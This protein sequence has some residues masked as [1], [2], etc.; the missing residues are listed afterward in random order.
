MGQRGTLSSLFR[1]DLHGLSQA[2]ATLALH[3]RLSQLATIYCVGANNL[4]KEIWKEEKADNGRIKSMAKKH[5]LVIIVGRGL[6]SIKHPDENSD[7]GVLGDLVEE[8]LVKRHLKAERVD[9]NQGRLIVKGQ[10]LVTWLEEQ[11]QAQQQDMMQGSAGLRMF[12]FGACS[13]SA[14]AFFIV[15]PVLLRYSSLS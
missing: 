11:K 10:D 5:G 12:V 15:M 1:L 8:L 9:G 3:A 4:L 6:R 7:N 14:A 13:A 2:S